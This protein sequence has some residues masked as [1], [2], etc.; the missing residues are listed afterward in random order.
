VVPRHHPHDGF[1]LNQLAP[2][3]TG[4]VP[5]AEDGWAAARNTTVRPW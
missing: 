1:G 4:L 3:Q 2:A 5:Q